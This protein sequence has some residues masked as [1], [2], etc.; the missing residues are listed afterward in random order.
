MA[1]SHILPFSANAPGGMPIEPCLACLPRLGL[2]ILYTIGDWTDSVRCAF[3][4]GHVQSGCILCV[5]LLR[6]IP[7]RGGFGLEAALTTFSG[8]T[9][10]A[11]LHA[12]G[13]LIDQIETDC[14]SSEHRKTTKSIRSLVAHRNTHRRLELLP[15]DLQV[16]AQHSL[17]PRQK[18]NAVCSLP[19][20]TK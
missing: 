19:S 10:E 17:Q 16:M 9:I 1:K 2:A 13:F 4:Q 15:Q 8:R 14:R 5:P 11:T 3:G 7:Q 18:A 20:R 12:Q 6:E